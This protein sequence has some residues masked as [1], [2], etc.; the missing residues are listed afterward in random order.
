MEPGKASHHAPGLGSPR[1]SGLGKS[2]SWV[3]PCYADLRHHVLETT[4]VPHAL[5]CP[6]L[7]SRLR[8][9]VKPGAPPGPAIPLLGIHPKDLETGV[10]TE[11]RTRVLTAALATTAKRWTQPNCPPADEQMNKM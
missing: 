8:F 3:D 2:S 4:A 9:P 11:A 7:R 6:H 10:P 1:G 5:I